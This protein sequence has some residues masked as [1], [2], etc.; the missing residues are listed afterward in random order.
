[1]VIGMIGLGVMGSAMSTHLLAAGF[2]VTGFDIDDAALRRHAERG[3]AT[4]ASAAEVAERSDVVVTSLPS[5]AALRQTIKGIAPAGAPGLIV[6]ETSTLPLDNKLRAHDALT[7]QGI[8]LLD[9]PLSGT[10]AQAREKDLVVYVS[11]DDEAAKER[12]G[13][14]L[15]AFSRGRHDAGP[16]GNGTRLK[17]VANLLVAVH[18]V[19]T[20]EALLLARAAGL[21]PGLTLRA[22]GDGAGASRM[23]QVRGPMMVDGD[24]DE[25][26]MRVEAFSKDLEI[27]ASYAESVHSPT[28]LFD[29]ST[30]V[31]N[32]ALADGRGAQD[33]ACV[34]DV[35]DK[36]GP[37][38]T[39]S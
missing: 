12:V 28:P 14:V 15:D 20:A 35:L 16:F 18:N 34:Y 10:G 26:A 38:G 36:P 7:P 39:P 25:P 13:P 19:A 9:C 31:Y 22:V 5:K 37:D 2:P 23:F 27:I 11:G 1:M 32:A 24:Y 4:A 17:I 3:G 8:V 29:A 21:D 33:T 6:V 30:A